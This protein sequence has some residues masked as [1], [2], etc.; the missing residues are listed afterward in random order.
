MVLP[1][2]VSDVVLMD[3][4]SDAVLPTLVTTDRGELHYALWR[5]ESQSAAA[6]AQ[7]WTCAES[8]RLHGDAAA[9]GL[10][11]VSAVGPRFTEVR[12]RRRVCGERSASLC[13]AR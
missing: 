9:V 3:G 12:T 10:A 2:Q 6:A 11:S 7:R 4:A 1:G 5:P 13:V 8:V